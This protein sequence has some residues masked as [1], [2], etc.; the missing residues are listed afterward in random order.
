MKTSNTG[1]DIE[2]RLEAFKR[3]ELIDRPIVTV[4]YTPPGIPGGFDMGY[5]HDRVF[6]DG[7][8][9]IQLQLNSARQYWVGGDTRGTRISLSLGPDECAA[10]CGAGIGWSDDSTETNWSIPVVESWDEHGPIEVRHDSEYWAKSLEL[11]EGNTSKSKD[12]TV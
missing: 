7:A 3:G 6:G 2:Q 9:N 8:A 12:S 4:R 10:F 11:K 1:I 5:Y